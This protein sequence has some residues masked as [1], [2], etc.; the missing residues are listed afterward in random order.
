MK[1]E[2]VTAKSIVSL[3]DDGIANA[4]E[5][6]ESNIIEE[7]CLSQQT[8]VEEEENDDDSES[9]IEKSFKQNQEKPS[10]SKV[11]SALDVLKDATL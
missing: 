2:D 11:G 1:P 7:L 6:A 8:K 3:D 9:S 4:P 5:I 10:R